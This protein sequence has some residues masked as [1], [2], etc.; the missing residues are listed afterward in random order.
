MDALQRK[1]RALYA[2]AR[3]ALGEWASA[4][5]ALTSLVGTACNVLSRLRFLAADSSF[6]GLNGEDTLPELCRRAQM[7]ALDGVL[8]SAHEQ[9]SARLRN[10]TAWLA[11][12][13]CAARR[14]R[15]SRPPT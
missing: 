15:C 5:S 6:S 8:R 2:S 3:D 4:Q 10:A 7:A 9:V 13:P 14:S 1:Q 11:E 12:P